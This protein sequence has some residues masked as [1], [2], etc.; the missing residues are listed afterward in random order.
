LKTEKTQKLWDKGFAVENIANG[1][2]SR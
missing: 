2:E 1:W